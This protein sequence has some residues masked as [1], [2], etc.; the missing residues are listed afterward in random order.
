MERLSHARQRRHEMHRANVDLLQL[1]STAPPNP[2]IV[3]SVVNNFDFYNRVNS[4]L[5][6]RNI[7]KYNSSINYVLFYS[8]LKEYIDSGA[9]L[10]IPIGY[11]F[12]YLNMNVFAPRIDNVLVLCQ[13]VWTR[14]RISIATPIYDISTYTGVNTRLQAAMAKLNDITSKLNQLQRSVSKLHTRRQSVDSRRLESSTSVMNELIR[15]QDECETVV[16]AVVLHYNVDYVDGFIHG[17][18]LDRWTVSPWGGRL[19]LPYETITHLNVDLK[20]P[21]TNI[22]NIGSGYL[23]INFLGN[24]VIRTGHVVTSLFTRP[25]ITFSY[26][27]VHQV[28]LR[29]PSLNSVMD[30]FRVYLRELPYKDVH[31]VFESMVL[32]GEELHV[33][34]EVNRLADFLRRLEA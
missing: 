5:G 14:E 1:V 27:L 29:C 10:I 4:L 20:L 33:H 3:N 17:V 7:L 24:V 18:V 25:S 30:M 13:P 9:A 15:R 8:H 12:D 32:V 31:A 22:Y 19:N 21:N 26:T 34:F 16:K 2:E 6:R 28:T 23:V 11:L